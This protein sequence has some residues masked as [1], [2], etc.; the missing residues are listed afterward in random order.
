MPEI[1]SRYAQDMAEKCQRYVKD[2]RRVFPQ[3]SKTLITDWVTVWVSNMDPRDG[4]ASK[5]QYLK[6][7]NNL[8]IFDC[9]ILGW[10]TFFSRRVELRLWPGRRIFSNQEFKLWM[11]VTLALAWSLAG[12]FSSHVCWQDDETSEVFLVKMQLVFFLHIYATCKSLQEK[13]FSGI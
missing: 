9:N 10:R 13:N 4:S 3:I 8:L 1:C 6:L 5:N 7:A 12:I 11:D 2:T